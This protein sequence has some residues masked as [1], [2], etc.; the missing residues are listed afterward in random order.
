MIATALAIAAPLAATIGGLTYA[1]VAPACSFWGAVTSRGPR[2]SGKIAL[3]FD[4]G[5]T[6]GATDR[7]LDVL[8]EAGVRAAFF[9]VGANVRRYAGLLRRVHDEGH[10]IGNHS[11][12]HSHYGVMGMQRYW[13]DEVRATDE[14]IEAVLGVRPAMFRPP[15]GIKTW[16]TTGAARRHGHALVTWSRRAIDGLPTTPQRIVERL[17]ELAAGDIILL[18]DGVEPHARHTDRSATVEAIAPLLDRIKSRGLS[19][20]RLDELTGLRGYQSRGHTTD[21]AARAGT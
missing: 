4:D 7:V 5:P 20:V 18:H 8:G 11:F 19:P 14:T 15:M 9:V 3:T 13:D 1:T 6:P 21:S 12:S 2:G 16:H 10:L 17:G